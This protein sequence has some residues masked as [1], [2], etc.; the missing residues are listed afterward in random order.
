MRDTAREYYS[1]YESQQVFALVLNNLHKLY[2]MLLLCRDFNFIEKTLW[3]WNQYA[4]LIS[5][6]FYYFLVLIVTKHELKI[7]EPYKLISLPLTRGW[8]WI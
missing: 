3:N 6:E 4:L 7:W 8:G 1:F 2:N 5:F